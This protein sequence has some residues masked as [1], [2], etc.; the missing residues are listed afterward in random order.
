MD[1]RY[2]IGGIL[3]GILLL[4][5]WKHVRL[6]HMKRDS[7]S[8]YDRLGGVFAIASVVDYFSD[9]ILRSPVVGANSPNPKL[10]NWST[11]QKAARMPGLKFM[12][13]LWVCDIAGGPQKYAASKNAVSGGCIFNSS[14]F[15]LTAAHKDLNISSAEFDEV[16]RILGDSLDHFKVPNK[17]KAEVLA[18]FGAHKKDIVDVGAII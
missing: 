18:A 2:A 8:L 11:Q 12:R 7:I 17:E 10:R 5:A 1:L 3:V 16:A 6:C 9:A 13:T 4:V 14:K 15:D